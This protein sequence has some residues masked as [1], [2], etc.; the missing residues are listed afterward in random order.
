MNTL[1]ALESSIVVDSNIITAIQKAY[2]H[3]YVFASIYD[4]L[5]HAS[6]TNEQV[7][8]MSVKHFE[9]RD[10]LLYFGLYRQDVRNRL[11]IPVDAR[12][13]DDLMTI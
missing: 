6:N 12:L 2:E 1:N 3:D 4:Y 13:P 10:G 9:F 8:P 11:C 5:Q 7:V